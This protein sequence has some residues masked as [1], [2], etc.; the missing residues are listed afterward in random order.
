L[1]VCTL[2]D[3]IPCWFGTAVRLPRK[4]YY[5][6]FGATMNLRA[7]AA[8]A[9]FIELIALIFSTY[10]YVSLLREL[11]WETHFRFL[12]MQPIYLASEAVLVLFFFALASELKKN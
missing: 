2:A 5:S 11:D 3:L 10:N 4:F 9:A 7:I 6:R 12:A 1:N 8:L